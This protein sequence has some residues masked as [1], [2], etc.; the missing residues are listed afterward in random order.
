MSLSMMNTPIWLV[1]TQTALIE[2][3]SSTICSKHTL[4]HVLHSNMSHSC[5]PTIVADNAATVY[6][7]YNGLSRRKF[8]YRA[9]FKRC[10]GSVVADSIVEN[11]S[12][13]KA[14]FHKDG[15]T[16]DWF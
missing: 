15:Q 12:C 7:T 4:I 9:Y 2:C 10:S 11:I 8:C 14:A 6:I 3:K 16:A 5:I 1:T 13:L